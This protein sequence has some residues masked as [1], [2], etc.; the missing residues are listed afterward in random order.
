MAN[1]RVS[2]VDM[3]EIVRLVRAGESNSTIAQVLGCNRRTVIKYRQWITE[4]GLL[5]GPLPSAG[6]VQQLL[7]RSLPPALPPQQRSSLAPYREEICTLREQGVGASTCSRCDANVSCTVWRGAHGKG[8]QR[9]SPGA[10]PTAPG[11]IGPP[12]H[13][14]NG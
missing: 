1:R 5:E 3:L 2:T 9:T 12:A 13:R 7:T 4:Q 8:R 6:V 11:R 10:Y 14:V